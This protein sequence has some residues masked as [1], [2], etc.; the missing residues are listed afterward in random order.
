MQISEER[1]VALWRLASERVPVT[2]TPVA[3]ALL[4][5]ETPDFYRQLALTLRA[6]EEVPF[7]EVIAHLRRIGYQERDPVE[8]VGEFS[9]RGGILDVFSPE[10]PRPVRIEF[11]GDLVE[12][13]RLFDVESQRSVLKV[14]QCVLLP[15]LECPKPAE[16]AAP[17]WEFL[18]AL[19]R[20]R[21]GTLASLLENPIVVLDEPERLRG[22]AG[23]LWERL[24]AGAVSE[25]C[26]PDKFFFRWEELEDRL[27]GA[28]RVAFSELGLGA[29]A[30]E[31]EISSRPS[32]AF[33]GNM[34][35]AV[36]EV[37]NVVEAGGRAVFFAATTGELERLADVFH[38]YAVPFQLGF[39]LAGGASGF[40]AERAYF[41]GSVASTFLVKGLVRRGTVFP[42]PLIAI[43]GS[44]DLFDTSEMVARLPAK[45]PAGPFAADLADLK[46]GDYVVHAQHGVGRFLGLREVSHGQEPADYMV[47]EYAG[48]AT[49]LRPFDPHGS[50]AEV[51]RRRRR[52]ARAGQARRRD[53]G[54]HEEAGQGP[55]ARHGRGTPQ[56]VRR[57]QTGR[58]LLLLARQQLAEG[59]RGRFRIHR[60]QGPANRHPGS[61]AGHGEPPADGPAA[62]RRRRFR[63]DG[64]GH[65]RGV[66]GPGRRAPGRGAGPHYRPL[67]PALRDLPA[68]LRAL[69]GARRDAEPFRAARRAPEDHLR[70]EG[71][72]G[73]YRHRHAPPVVQGC[74]VPRPGPA[75]GRRRAALRRAP[76]GAAQAD[77]EERRCA[78][79]ERH[80]HPA[81]PAH[82]SA[83]AAGHVRDRD[84][85][86]GPPRHPHGGRAL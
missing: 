3:A 6:E 37:R 18:T 60:D 8:M 45:R 27:S 34:P 47:L 49:A 76:Q 19:E 54:A 35:V 39:E 24:E 55:D 58:G 73:G 67:L 11:L 25:P 53:L 31:S 69:P 14:E 2:V 85:P 70:S 12:S 15:L 16:E 7:D 61:Q 65:A 28:P 57:A 17:G 13:M 4:R 42:D 63:Q 74:R 86:Q 40:L 50:G 5:T 36:A 59:V 62:V 66:Q 30:P 72:Q 71:W 20:P 51:S 1:A 78:D 56:V 32:M 75:D 21:D 23:R 9:L 26:P 80:A 68:A 44:E 77:P 83:G 64:S 52:G 22:A 48:E 46:A 41:A 29:A 38:E 81:H 33:H 82:V 10:S 79:H 43:F 84:A